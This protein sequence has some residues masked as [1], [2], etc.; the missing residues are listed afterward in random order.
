MFFSFP[1]F[2]TCQ[3]SLNFV[4][5]NMRHE[6]IR[7]PID[8]SFVPCCYAVK[9]FPAKAINE[10]NCVDKGECEKTFFNDR[11]FSQTHQ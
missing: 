4:S 2:E 11:S 10:F 1:L 9:R 7:P 3:Q 8:Q 6:H 5:D